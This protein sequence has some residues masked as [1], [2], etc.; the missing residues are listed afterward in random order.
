V[1]IQHHNVKIDIDNEKSKYAAKRVNLQ[2]KFKDGNGKPIAGY[3]FSASVT[4]NGAVD[5]PKYGENIL[6]RLLLSADLKG[7]IENPGYYFES[8]Q[9]AAKDALDSGH[10]D[11]WLESLRLGGH[12]QQI[13]SHDTILSRQQS[14]HHGKN[15]HAQWN[16]AKQFQVT[17]FADKWGRSDITEHWGKGF[18]VDTTDDNGVFTF[19]NVHFTD[20]TQFFVQVLNKRGNDKDVKIDITQSTWPMLV[21]T[22]KPGNDEPDDAGK[23]RKYKY[24]FRED[25]L[26]TGRGLTLKTITIKSNKNL[27]L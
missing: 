13:F 11:A 6:T 17:L 10:A 27:K 8:N 4:D 12:H 21:T 7:Y 1:F 22:L 5:I 9:P 2:L 23:V 15:I 25:I 16:L 3:Y 19:R 18:A 20:S 26:N 14:E 24:L